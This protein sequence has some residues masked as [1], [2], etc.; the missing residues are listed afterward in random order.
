MVFL[1]VESRWLRSV[2]VRQQEEPGKSLRRAPWQV[3]A[4]PR[5]ATPG[6]AHAFLPPVGAQVEFF[7]LPERERPFQ[8][9]GR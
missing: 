1:Q 6:V 2:S 7:P 8:A 3:W 4:D 5:V 9:G